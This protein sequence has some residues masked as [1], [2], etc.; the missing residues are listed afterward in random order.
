MNLF[1]IRASRGTI[2]LRWLILRLM[3]RAVMLGVWAER[4][5]VIAGLVL[6]H[7][8]LQAE[9]TLEPHG[10]GSVQRGG[11]GEDDAGALLVCKPRLFGPAVMTSVRVPMGC[12][13][14]QGGGSCRKTY[15]SFL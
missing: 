8:Q 6:I 5:L 15:S 11:E 4:R 7:G 2:L 3:L 1:L 14:E 10:Q 13:A 9:N 12:E